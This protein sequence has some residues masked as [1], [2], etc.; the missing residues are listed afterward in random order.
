VVWYDSTNPRP[1]G[2]FQKQPDGSYTLALNGVPFPLLLPAIWQRMDAL[3]NVQAIYTVPGTDA[4]TDNHDL[5]VLPD[6]DVLFMGGIKTIQDLSAYDGGANATVLTNTLYR[7][8][9]DGGV[10]FA[11]SALDHVGLEDV[12]PGLASLA[13]NGLDENHCNAVDVASDGNYLVSSRHMSQVWKIDATTGQLRW[14]LGYHGDFTFVNDPLNGHTGQHYVREIA[15]DRILMFDNGNGHSP[16]QSRAAEYQLAFD[17]VTGAPTTATLMWSYVPSPPVFA[18]A[19]G[20]AQRLANGNTL[21]AFGI[22]PRVDEVDASGNL[23]WQLT[24]PSN[25]IYRA[26]LIDTLY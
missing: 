23:L 6:G 14:K 9:A 13:T 12:D 22:V 20:S 26:Q 5:R 16:K 21:V 7:L 25:F 19:M 17:P 10:A 18:S 3:G 11:W 24:A 8:H 2:D 1:A 15:P 4:G